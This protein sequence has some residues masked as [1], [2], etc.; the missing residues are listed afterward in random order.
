MKLNYLRIIRRLIVEKFVIAFDSFW[1]FY[2][3]TFMLTRKK[4][5]DFTILIF[6]PT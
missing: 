5:F 3:L 2:Q 4:L 6:L 1:F